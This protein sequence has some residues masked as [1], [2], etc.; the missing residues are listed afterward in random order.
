MIFFHRSTIGYTL[1]LSAITKSNSFAISPRY[2]APVQFANSLAMTTSA[3]TSANP[4]LD[5]HKFLENVL[6]PE[7]LE[8]VKSQNAACL[9]KFGE[10]TQT[11][12]KFMRSTFACYCV[13]C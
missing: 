5:P 2:L 8:W 7:S 4:S 1:F 12:G 10:P 3:S 6:S 9:S 11:E 13:V